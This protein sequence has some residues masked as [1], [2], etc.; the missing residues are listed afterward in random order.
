MISRSIIALTRAFRH[1]CPS[2]SQETP[3]WIFKGSFAR[4]K[5]TTT[6]P[7]SPDGLDLMTSSPMGYWKAM[8]LNFYRIAFLDGCFIASRKRGCS[9]DP[10]AFL[11]S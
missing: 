7:V 2:G 1:C 8:L 10:R 6:R 9:V 11:L 5:N 4:P 3:L